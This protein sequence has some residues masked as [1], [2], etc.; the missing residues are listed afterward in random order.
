MARRPKAP[1][2]I[3]TTLTSRQ[4]TQLIRECRLTQEELAKAIDVNPSTVY[5]HVAGLV[6]P[7]TKQMRAY[8]RF[9]AEKLNRPIHL[10]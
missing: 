1:E 4:L 9:F 2:S 10:I 8:E 6:Q 7:R 5:R 3:I